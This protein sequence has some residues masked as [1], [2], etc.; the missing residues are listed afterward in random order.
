M[1]QNCQGD[2]TMKP[3]LILIDQ[4]TTLAPVDEKLF[5]IF[6]PSDPEGLSFRSE[7]NI[8]FEP[9]QNFRSLDEMFAFHWPSAP[10]AIMAE[11]MALEWVALAFALTRI[12]QAN[13][14]AKH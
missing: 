7:S 2:G 5:A 14:S 10:V 12:P 6:D 8:P 9:N 1:Q 3:F 11:W 4:P 13:E